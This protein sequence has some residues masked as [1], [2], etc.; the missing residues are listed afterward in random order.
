M[1]TSAGLGARLTAW[2]QPRDWRT[3][4]LAPPCPTCTL[5]C[6]R[7]A[8]AQLQPH[9]HR[10]P[11]HPTPP[12]VP[13]TPPLPPQPYE[14]GDPQP[15]ISFLGS[16]LWK[17]HAH[18]PGW[19]VALLFGLGSLLFLVTGIARQTRAVSDPEHW[20]PGL[21]SLAAGLS[22]WPETVAC[23]VMYLPATIL[24]VRRR[25]IRSCGGCQ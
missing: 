4:G 21:A 9:S 11:P 3:A 17:V 7:A 23:W 19:W 6:V 25:A 2:R 24:Q 1:S 8:A 18:Q 16:L 15:P 13:A 12:P 20:P 5:W 14:V 10:S 22:A